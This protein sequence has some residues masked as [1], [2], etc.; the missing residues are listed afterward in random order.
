MSRVSFF[1]SIG[2]IFEYNF[3]WAKQNYTV[4]QMSMEKLRLTS[5]PKGKN[6]SLQ[7]KGALVLALLPLPAYANEDDALLQVSMQVG[8]VIY[9]SVIVS[10]FV[11]N[12][13]TRIILFVVYLCLTVSAYV[14]AMSPILELSILYRV[15][16]CCIIPLV[17]TIVLAIL[18]G[19]WRNT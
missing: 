11:R 9:A 18:A 7:K 1:V 5:C 19:L 16:I 6:W 8:S 14:F 12:A 13:K 17:S 10:L 2:V 4:S 15:I 3:C